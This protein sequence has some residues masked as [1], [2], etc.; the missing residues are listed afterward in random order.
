VGLLAAGMAGP[1]RLSG[2]LDGGAPFYDVYETADGQH[3]TV[4]PLESQFWQAFRDRIGVELPDRD[5]PAAWPEL[6]R[7]LT[8]T[9]RSRTKA[10][11]LKVFEGS[12]ACVGPVTAYADAAGDPHLE[13]RGTF[14]EHD[15][16]VQPA[17]APR[18]SRTAAAL[19]DDLPAEESDVLAAWGV[20]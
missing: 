4:A 5:D 7:I 19:R 12:D 2:V 1:R 16:V 11:W 18:F 6:R 8:E 20:E 13:A 14:V 15:G 3:L 9:L 10:E 17:P